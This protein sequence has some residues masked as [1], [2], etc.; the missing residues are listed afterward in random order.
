MAENKTVAVMVAGTGPS[1]MIAAL[2]LAEA[3]FR[4]VLAGPAPSAG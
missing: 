4:P 3:G 1:G 2:T